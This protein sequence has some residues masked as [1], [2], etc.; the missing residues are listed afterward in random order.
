[1]FLYLTFSENPAQYELKEIVSNRRSHDPP[2]VCDLGPDKNGF[3]PDPKTA[4]KRL[5]FFRF[6]KIWIHENVALNDA[7]MMC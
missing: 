3:I 7:N 5:H 2:G 1:M 4:K 6:K